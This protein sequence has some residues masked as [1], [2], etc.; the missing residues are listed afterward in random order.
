MKALKN[1]KANLIAPAEDGSKKKQS[2]SLTVR[3]RVSAITL[4]KTGLSLDIGDNLSGLISGK[5]I[6]A[7]TGTAAKPL[8]SWSISDSSV[9]TICGTQNGSYSGSV[10]NATA[11]YVKAGSKAGTAK[12]TAVSEN[13]KKATVSVT[14]KGSVS[15]I[16]ISSGKNLHTLAVGKTLSL[17]S[18]PGLSPPPAWCLLSQRAPP[19]LRSRP[20]TAAARP[21]LPPTRSR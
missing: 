12:L 20:G 16:V 9:A 19:A 5:A 4:D 17:T 8:L 14:V 6:C 21:P 18:K 10:S 13:G 7:S 2:I 3:T 11:V 15:D 1:G